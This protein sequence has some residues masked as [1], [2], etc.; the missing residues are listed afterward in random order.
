VSLPQSTHRVEMSDFWRAFHH[1]GK[2]SMHWLV[3]VGGARPLPFTLQYLSS[4]TKLQC[5]LQLRGQIHSPYFIST[6]YMYSVVCSMLPVENCIKVL[7]VHL[8]IKKYSC[9]SNDLMASSKSTYRL[10]VTTKFSS[11]KYIIWKIPRMGRGRGA[12]RS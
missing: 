4:R 8:E 2:S 7:T 3:R 11:K 9:S 6:P 1:D 12:T 5:T 10:I